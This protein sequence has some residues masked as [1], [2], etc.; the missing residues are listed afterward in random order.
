MNPVGT[1]GLK[2]FL[3]LCW[4]PKLRAEA[5]SC[6]LVSI[7]CTLLYL[8]HLITYG[9]KLKKISNIY[10][11]CKIRAGQGQAGHVRPCRLRSPL[12]A[13][14]PGISCLKMG[15]PARARTMAAPLSG[16]PTPHNC[17]TR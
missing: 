15:V 13:A 16:D 1:S 7:P 14:Y 2:V 8:I 11:K 6:V 10:H 17:G 12:D 3:H 9:T 5:V 4:L